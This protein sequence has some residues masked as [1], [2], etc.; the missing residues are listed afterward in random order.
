MPFGSSTS[1]KRADK[2]L[3]KHLKLSFARPES[4]ELSE[5]AKVLQ[6][7]S[8]YTGGELRRVH[9]PERGFLKDPLTP[10]QRSV[11]NAQLTPSYAMINDMQQQTLRLHVK[12]RDN[13][14]ELVSLKPQV[15]DYSALFSHRPI[16]EA[17]GPYANKKRIFVLRKLVATQACLLTRGLNAANLVPQFEDCWRHFEVQRGLYLRRVVLV[18]RE[19]PTLRWDMVKMI[20]SSFTAPSPGLAGHMAGAAIDVRLRD[21]SDNRLLDLGNDYAEG[22]AGSSL[23]FPYLTSQ[24]WRTRVLLAEAMRMAGFKL[25]DTE[26]WHGSLGDRGLSHDGSLKMETAM[27]GPVKSFKVKSGEVELFAAEEIDDY[28]L[29]DAQ[30]KALIERSREVSTEGKDAWANPV[31]DVVNLFRREQLPKA[32]KYGKPD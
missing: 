29:T 30:I 6:K 31:L 17:C 21:M 16:H 32:E 4:T 7:I 27:Y 11:L 3:E 19:F 28:F 8:D 23:R 9:P 1:Y 2:S 13:G 15:S 26:D 24:Q 10:E 5:V 18:A 12:I 25:L 20:A 14:E 22:G